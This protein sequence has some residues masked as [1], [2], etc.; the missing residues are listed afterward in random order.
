MDK[1]QALALKQRTQLKLS[2]P[3]L[4]E[5]IFSYV[6][7]GGSIIELCNLWDVR[8]YDMM[9]WIRK[10][11]ARSELYDSAVDA[12]LHYYVTRL[13][14]E[15]KAL[16]TVDLADAYDEDGQL[17]PLR[18]MPQHVRAAIAAVDR[19]EQVGEDGS[20]TTV[21]VK[22][23]DKLKA[24]EMLGNQLGIFNRTL[25]V[26]VGVTLEQLVGG[27]REP[28]PTTATEVPDGPAAA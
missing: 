3:N 16:A 22:L 8:Y 1:E 10:E 4:I 14:D 15:V 12:W 24:I 5:D 17:L 26:K 27:S 28:I 2:E 25:N 13:M 6:A 9:R 21:K 7:N 11:P 18:E 19:T 20:K 23:W